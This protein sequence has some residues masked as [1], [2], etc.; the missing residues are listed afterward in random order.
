MDCCNYR[1]NIWNRSEADGRNINLTVTYSL[2]PWLTHPLWDQKNNGVELAK[3]RRGI[4]KTTALFFQGYGGARERERG[5]VH[6]TGKEKRGKQSA[7]PSLYACVNGWEKMHYCKWYHI[8]T[9]PYAYESSWCRLLPYPLLPVVHVFA[10]RFLKRL[11]EVGQAVLDEDVVPLEQLL[12]VGGIYAVAIVVGQ[13][14]AH[15]GM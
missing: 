5:C 11:I 7:R 10:L 2:G 15:V 1:H 14:L 13:H 8:C 6:G 12:D 4:G 9:S 3:Q